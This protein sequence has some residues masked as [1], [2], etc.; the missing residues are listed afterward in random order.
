MALYNKTVP[1]ASLFSVTHS[2]RIA[3]REEGPFHWREHGW[4]CLSRIGS[5]KSGQTSGKIAVYLHGWLLSMDGGMT[6][7]HVGNLER[8]RETSALTVV[9]LMGNCSCLEMPPGDVLTGRRKRR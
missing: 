4:L 7:R 8:E 5:C 2:L 6:A 9:P 1:A 3:Q